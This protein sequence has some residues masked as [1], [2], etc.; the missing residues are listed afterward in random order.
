MHR[1]KLIVSAIALGVA[2]LALG[3]STTDHPNLKSNNGRTGVNGDVIN[4]DPGRLTTANGLTA[5]SL[6]WYLPF[7]SNT[8]VESLRLNEIN[9]MKTIIDNTDAGATINL[10]E[11]GNDVG[12]YDP[13]PNGAV[14][15]TGTWFAPT[16]DEA[17]Q[18]TYVPVIRRNANAANAAPFQGRNPNL[19]W[20]AHLW[21]ATTSS[22]GGVG[23]DPR[24]AIVPA[25]LSTFSW[26]FSPRISTLVAGNYVVT[27]DA[28]PKGYALYVWIPAGLVSPGGVSRP[29]PR[30]MSY[31]VTYGIGQKY[32]DVVDT[33]ASGFGWV[34]LG[35]GGHPTNQ[36]FQYAGL[37][38]LG[39]PYPITIKLYNTIVRNSLD[40]LTETVDATHP[41]NRFS[42]LADAALFSAETDSYVATPTSAGFG[43]TDIRVI[44]ARNE[45]QIDPNSIPS[46]TSTDW[47]AKP[48]SIGNGVVRSYDYNTGTERW[49]YSPL[50]E[51][52]NTTSF[53]DTNVRFIASPGFTSAADNAN[54]RGGEYLKGTVD[55]VAVS[56][57]VTVDPQTDLAEGS[58]D[59]YM[60]VGG[61]VAGVNYA[62]S[63]QYEIFEGGV[64]AGQFT[65]DMSKGGWVRLG[66]RR[67]V[68]SVANPLTV[69]M[70]NHSA[71][72]T[73]AGK[74]IYVDQF[75][76]VGAVGT[77][78]TSTPVEAEA[79]VRQTPGVDPV[80]TKVVI[81]ADERGYLHCLDATGNADGTTTCYWTYPSSTDA[82]NDPNLQPGQDPTDPN[83]GGVYQ[84]FDGESDTLE[85]TMPTDFD[86]STAVVQR[87]TVTTPGGPIDRDFL[88]IGS[89]NGRIYSIAMEGRGD[90]SAT[91]HT[92]GTTFRSWTYPETFPAASPQP[93]LL[94]SIA[95]VVSGTTTGGQNVIYVATEQGRIYC[96]DATGDFNYSN[97]KE[98][99]TSVVWQYPP[100]T[101]DTLPAI[102]GAPVLDQVNHRLFF[103]THYVDGNPSRFMALNADTGA[104]LWATTNNSINDAIGTPPTQLDWFS[105]ACYV[106][107]AELNTNPTAAAQVMPD[108][109][110]AMNENGNVYA[111]NAGTG[112]VLWRTNELQSGGLGSIVYTR[113]ITYDTTGAPAEFPV[114]MVPTDSGRFA[115][116]FARLGEETRFGNRL[117][118]GYEMDASIQATMT[119]SNKWLFGATTNG[120]LLAWSD[121]ANAGST[122]TGPGPGNETAADND[123]AYDE[124]RNCEV[125]FL[126]RAGFV[127]LR[128]NL[129]GAITG[130]EPYANVIDTALPYTKPYGRLKAPYKS[131]HGAAFEWG[132]TIYLIAYNFPYKTQ[133]TSGNDVAPP[134][135]EA[136][137]T[138]EGRAS[139]PIAA[140]ARLFS[141]KTSADSDGGYA[142]F[143][144]PLTAGGG[145]AQTPGPGSIRVQ[146]RTSA[147]NNNNT[148]QSITLNPALTN[149]DY[150]VANPIGISVENTFTTSGTSTEQ[151]GYTNDPTR[152][153][154]LANGSPNLTVT[155]VGLV[156]GLLFGKSVG[157]TAH[158]SAKKTN[159]YVFDR[160]LV[161]LLRGE[162]RGIDLVKVD[163][164]D[165][166]WQGGTASI[167]KPFALVPGLGALL[168]NFEDLPVNF[169]N[170]SLDYPDIAREDV[171]V[172][173]EPNGNVENPVFNPVSLKGP[174]TA[175]G[176]GF[177]DES[178]AST[179][180]IVPTTFEFEVDVPKYQP[181]NAGNIS[182]PNQNGTFWQAGY[183]GRFTVYVDSDQSGSFGGS[184][185]EAYRTFNLGAA[186]SPDEK[187]T[188]GTPNVDL[189]SL[190]A[191]AGYDTRLTYSPTFP[192]RTL[193]PTTFFSPY[194]AEYSNM[195]KPFSA[196]NDGN[197][198][199]W[200]VRLAKGTYDVTGGLYWPWEVK[201]GGNNDDIWLDSA[202]DVQSNIDGRFSPV[203]GGGVNT[204]FAAK[205]RVGDSSGKQIF[206]NPSSRINSNLPGSG[207]PLVPN[208]ANSPTIVSVTPP[209][210]TPIGKYSQLMRLVEDT[211]GTGPAIGANDESLSLGYT[212]SGTVVP[213]ES[214]SDPTFILSFTVKETQMTGGTSDYT[215]AIVDNGNAVDA[216]H[217]SQWA[218]MQPSGL[219]LTSGS[220]MVA[221]ASNRPSFYPAAGNTTPN[222][223][224]THIFVGLV[225]GGQLGA[226]DSRGQDSQIRDLNK[227]VPDDPANRRWMQALAMLPTVADT[228]IFGNTLTSGVASQTNIG[229]TL[230]SDVSYGNPV[231]STN[232]D[233]DLAGLSQARTYVVYTGKAKRQTDSGVVDDSRIIVTR[234]N[235]S[236]PPGQ[237]YVLDADPFSLK[238]RPTMVQNG[239]NV[240]IFYPAF[241]NG[242]W[243]IY[244]TSF[245]ESTGFTVPQMLQFGTGFETVSSPSVVLRNAVL[246]G[247]ATTEYDLTFTGRLRNSNVDEVFMARLDPNLNYRTFGTTATNGAL[248]ETGVYDARY[249]AYR[250]RG[251]AW[252]GD[253]D[254]TVNGSSIITSTPV[255]DRQTGIQAATTIF[256]GRVVVDPMLG[257]VK[258][259]GATL[260]KSAQLQVT[261][262]PTFLR[263]SDTSVAGYNSTSALFDRRLESSNTAASYAFW[264]T[265][266][267]ND[268]PATSANTFADRLVVS[269][270]RSATSAA[271]SAQVSRPAMSTLRLGIRVGRSIL[272]N[273]D[274]S[275]AESVTVTGNTGSY[276]IDPAAGRIYFTRYDEDKVLRI[277]L[278]GGGSA[279]AVDISRPVTFIG[280][281]AENFITMDAPLNESN[282]FLFLDPVGTTTN[283]RGMIWMLWSSTRNGAPSIF[284]QTM[285]RKIVPVL[286][287]N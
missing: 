47:T 51:G 208:N 217:T 153:D 228:T 50:E 209:L 222:S 182:I 271:A 25:N 122:L 165:L 256:G 156:N 274:G 48:L 213:Y 37:D 152:E 193:S 97:G 248:V 103:G 157:T 64:S 116:L 26:V 184:S 263:L 236:G 191:G 112:D 126:S 88:I 287:P 178:N 181:A 183:A 195:F 34:R 10:D 172:R 42:V 204:I 87:L 243:S 110:F 28:T 74:S 221:F 215:D 163:R 33:E 223:R 79:Y 174:L 41:D 225:A 66:N 132:E 203:L 179:R 168:G 280:E 111:I 61:D 150:Q 57:N 99:K 210:G 56:Q 144:I 154:A 229:G 185:R 2:T 80:L 155:G 120:Y 94:G 273:A 186:V 31:E 196:Y 201:S 284:M 187:I 255:E 92:P 278:G 219:R 18:A 90:F 192:Y 285:A 23:G 124:Y 159:V 249:G 60:Y 272:V 135:V 65:L 12:P 58:Y 96:L 245:N 199:L 30:Y 220:L 226:N 169:P 21:A 176:I 54:A 101:S 11:F 4:S 246:N 237:T 77:Q 16:T 277:Q 147:V 129:S 27:N 251:A 173:K 100:Q 148:Q 227:F 188:I 266:S 13:L 160:S 8:P 205:P 141:D 6:R 190:S 253:F 131:T 69:M 218:D 109:V 133:D 244:A 252:S 151:L 83:A 81:V 63:A 32:V 197:V 262:T 55:T 117:A 93:T 67:Y 242:V 123:P 286:P 137:V 29:R 230:T 164:K 52:T 62:Q 9:P 108:T 171:Q 85:A 259:T 212:A 3:Q 104:T 15:S 106:S 200:N 261:Y 43:T 161:T 180:V 91:N 39:N 115:A 1:M 140:E 275:L 46:V 170:N 114:I 254:I 118:W 235:T 128:Q 177:V 22:L 72:A 105:G 14:A 146:L 145:T 125:A 121:L 59:V 216:A 40:Q 265:P 257:T 136:T 82:A 162:G 233:K 70:T 202:A 38:G 264:K 194:Q 214:F 24:Q 134:V 44:G 119:V 76:F 95:S 198:N 17:A 78:I 258:L 36:L 276:Q 5:S 127:A 239:N 35:N 279:A 98:L 207:F 142:I 7:V 269:A 143:Q 166:R 281:S 211:Q 19:R 53:E 267:G 86:L 232:G 189:G 49:R 234:I 231:F 73:D 68:H 241:S 158:G 138:T 130:T 149:L 75:R 107:A 45:V 84:K 250:V 113:I 206:V 247:T 71:N 102:S 224:N 238:G 268:E 167:Y 20:P 282:L 260:P 175:S 270:V 139:R 89:K 240:T 283:R